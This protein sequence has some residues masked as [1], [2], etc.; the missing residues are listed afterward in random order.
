[1]IV[2]QCRHGIMAFLGNDRYVGRSLDLYGEYGEGE[3]DLFRQVVFAGHTVVE[4]GANMGSLTVPL[5]RM[6]GP[7]GQVLAIEPQP[8]MYDL[9]V[10]NRELNNLGHVK[11]VQAGAGGAPGKM[12]L[13]RLPTNE[14]FNFGGVSLLKNSADGQEVP[15]VIVDDFDLPDVRFI[16]IDVEG[17]EADVLRGS[18]NTINRCRPFLFVE[19]DRQEKS[20]ELI[21]LLADYGY[22]MWWHLTRLFNPL[23]Y[24][25]N[26][27][28]VFA[29]IASINMFCVPRE[30]RF[31]IT[32]MRKV[33]GPA[34]W[35]RRKPQQSPA[36]TKTT[37]AQ[38]RL[39]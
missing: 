2:R 5:A 32:S 38:K 28:N 17:M 1:M 24:T 27:Q 7:E 12:T 36:A 39:G 34:D 18:A 15:I 14:T 25:G 22:D 37:D 11:L 31:V 33:A 29:D 19:N 3:V 9:L 16:K 13:P 30:R 6:V 35:W 23:N 4:V 8:L 10:R 20:P 21:S 26:Q